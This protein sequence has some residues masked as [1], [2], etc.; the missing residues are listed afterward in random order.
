MFL[1]SIVSEKFTLIFFINPACDQHLLHL[2][3][4]VFH[5]PGEM[6]GPEGVHD[7]PARREQGHSERGGTQPPGCDERG[8]QR[9]DRWSPC[10][11]R[12]RC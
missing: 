4:Q 5:V 6:H 3:C 10:S 2:P 8:S 11:G 7:S 1:K 12:W 9:H